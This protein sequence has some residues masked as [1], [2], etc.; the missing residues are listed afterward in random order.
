M[1][2][3]ERQNYASIPLVSR[4]DRLD[5][6]MKYIEGKQNISSCSSHKLVKR[7]CQPVEMAVK[8]AHSRGSLL[9]RIAFLED[10]LIR[11]HFKWKAKLLGLKVYV[12]Y[13]EY[14]QLRLKIESGNQSSKVENSSSHAPKTNL[15]CSF[16]TFSNP[17]PGNSR[18]HPV[19]TKSFDSQGKHQRQQKRPKQPRS[20]QQQHCGKKD[21][22]KSTSV[23]KGA[24]PSW[25][26]FKV[27]G[28]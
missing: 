6:M 22:K 5:F 15:S 21:G 8:E 4:L 1:A 7:K 12:D 16:P 25:T 14:L 19:H 28:C 18:N 10:Q 26:H 13:C 27:L 23:K 11:N 2:D 17:N 24:P 3:E 9:D 20:M